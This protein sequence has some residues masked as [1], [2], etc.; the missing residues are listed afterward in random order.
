M[1]GEAGVSGCIVV[2]LAAGFGLAGLIVSWGGIL[3]E[4]YIS[5]RAAEL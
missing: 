1:A 2:G 3:K 4:F 5:W